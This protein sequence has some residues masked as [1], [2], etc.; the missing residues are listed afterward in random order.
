M[1]AVYLKERGFMKGEIFKLE[2]HTERLFY[3]AKEWVLL[4]RIHKQK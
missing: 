2:E 4:C 1:Q 3:S